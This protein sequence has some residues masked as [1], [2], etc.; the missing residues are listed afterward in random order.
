MSRYSG[1]VGFALRA[2]EAVDRR[3]DAWKLDQQYAQEAD[4]AFERICAHAGRRPERRQLDRAE[5]WARDVLGSDRF[6]PWLR[7]YVA[8]SGEFRE[9]WIPNNFYRRI[10]LPA[11]QGRAQ[12]LA[13]F[14]TLARRIMRTDLMP[15][16]AYLVDGNWLDIEG[17]SIEPRHVADLVY[18][19]GPRVVAKAD[20]SAQGRGV[21]VFERGRDDI[22]RLT[23]TGDFVIQRFVRQ[24]PFFDRFNPT[25][26]ATLRITTIKVGC[27]SARLRSAYLRLGRSDTETILAAHNLRV[28]IVDDRGSL[29][30]IGVAPDWERLSAHPDSG[31]AFAGAVIPAFDEARG[32]CESLHDR[33]PHVTVIGWDVAIDAEGR[34]QVLEWNSFHPGIVFAEMATG[35]NFADLGWERLRAGDAV[36]PC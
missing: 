9:G 12:P 6:A 29:G 33:L 10:V 25:N 11:I 20:A 7:S 4:E 8:W 14:K 15:D 34:A 3:A 21:T 17:R 24:A 31:E 5:G 1:V 2:A 28:P 27:E 18:R 32:A 23:G 16:V 22:V 36:P 13:S 30:E 19:D 35:P 26:V